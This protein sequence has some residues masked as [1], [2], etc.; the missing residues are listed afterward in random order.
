MSARS[1]WRRQTGEERWNRLGH[2]GSHPG[3]GGEVRV[4]QVGSKPQANRRRIITAAASSS[5]S[6]MTAANPIPQSASLRRRVSPV[7]MKPNTI[8]GMGRHRSAHRRPTTAHVFVRMSRATV[9]RRASSTG[10]VMAGNSCTWVLGCRPIQSR[11]RSTRVLA[12]L[13]GEEHG[14]EY[15]CR[16]GATALVGV[17][18][19]N[20]HDVRG[21]ST[22][23][24]HVA[25]RSGTTGNA[26]TCREGFSPD[27]SWCPR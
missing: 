24:S 27:R 13:F 10:L 1:R 5:A 6:I 16:R 12:P 14:S 25:S 7:A 15:R 22:S 19:Q 3:H 4:C 17:V 9:V 23:L 21:N 20:G 8:A 2:C 26:K 11:I 18:I